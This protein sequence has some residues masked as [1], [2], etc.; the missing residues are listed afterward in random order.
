MNKRGVYW[1][2]SWAEVSG[3]ILMV[4]GIVIA[5]AADSAF[6]NYV[7]ITLCGIVIGRLYAIRKA[8]IGT[9]FYMIVGFFLVG[10]LIGAALLKQRGQT[11]AL[12]V[13][14][15]IGTYFGNDW[16]KRKLIK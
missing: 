6:I 7:I 9:P 10:F 12:I 3:M 11:L 14:F 15:F 1:L 8:R 13:L 2:D 5:M 16:Y 4:V